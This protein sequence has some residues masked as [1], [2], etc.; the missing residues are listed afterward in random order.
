[1]FTHMNSPECLHVRALNR[2]GCSQSLVLYVLHEH[3]SM[4]VRTCV[5]AVYAPVYV[6]IT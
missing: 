4:H 1:M 2:V 3:A 6:F 5:F